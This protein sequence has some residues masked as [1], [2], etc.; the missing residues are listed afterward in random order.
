MREI[1]FFKI[2]PAFFIILLFFGFSY[3]QK[4]KQ[5]QA[6]EQKVRTVTIPISLFSKKELREK[7]AEE[8][9][10]ADRLIV[11][12]QGEEQIILS[13][14]SVSNTPLSLAILIQ[15]DLTENINLQLK[16]IA[17]FIRQMPR[18]SRVMV[19]YLRG[20]AIQVRQKFTEDLEKAANSLR[21]I[22]GS[23]S[24]AAGNPYDGV[25][26]VLDRFEALPAG[27]RAVLLISDGLDISHGIGSSS[28]GQ[29]IDL[30]RAITRAQRRGV[31]V[32]SF[33]ATGSF[34]QRANSFL[35]LNAQGS[36]LRLSEETGG[37]AFF[38]GSMTAVSFKPYF[39]DLGMMLNRQ[40]AL[41]YLSTHLKKGYYKVEVLSTNPEIK[42]EH[43]K[44]YYYR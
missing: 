18:G 1:K 13:I 43:P 6:N 31:A 30:D 22:T 32:Y 12:E 10:Q 42:I 7:Q 15:D 36:L 40:F 25:I 29:S 11:K 20:G 34:T 14:R 16:Q 3:A 4:G 38:Q 44:G 41:T 35:I 27:R 17:D 2:F 33:Y 8:F 5:R 19:A 28:P 21:I 24:V 9:I 39:S 23:P 37:R 26:E